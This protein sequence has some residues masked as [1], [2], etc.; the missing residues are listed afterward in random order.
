MLIPAPR[1]WLFGAA[2][3]AAAQLAHAGDWQHLLWAT[4]LPMLFLFATSGCMLSV[5]RARTA[6][7]TFVLLTV[8]PL[9]LL[10]VKG[11]LDDHEVT[12]VDSIPVAL[13]EVIAYGFNGDVPACMEPQPDTHAAREGLTLGWPSRDVTVPMGALYFGSI[14]VLL[15]SLAVVISKAFPRGMARSLWLNVAPLSV[16]ALLHFGGGM[17]NAEEPVWK[18]DPDLVAAVGPLVAAA[19]AALFVALLVA[20]RAAPKAQ[21]QQA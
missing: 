15:M 11:G 8:L 3:A 5:G 20:D 4:I 7:L 14:A 2:L 19:G 16:F 9:I 6:L 13:R 10:T 17:S 12:A 21:D 1:L 18:N